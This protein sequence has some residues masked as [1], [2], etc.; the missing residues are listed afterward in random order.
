MS[1][2]TSNNNA[3]L[4]VSEGPQNFY[5]MYSL[6]LILYFTST[7]RNPWYNF[8]NPSNS[9]IYRKEP[10]YDKTSLY[11]GSTVHVLTQGCQLGSWTLVKPK[12]EQLSLYS[13]VAEKLG[14]NMAYHHMS[15]LSENNLKIHVMLS[16]AL[17]VYYH[18]ANKTCY[19]QNITKN[20][21]T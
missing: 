7:K 6:T 11:R 3:I 2:D 10:L 17:N 1:T 15:A 5:S 8:F 16:L 12:Y 20:V 21:L 9:K 4:S 14:N 13:L 18:S 19:H